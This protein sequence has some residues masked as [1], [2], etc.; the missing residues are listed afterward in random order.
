MESRYLGGRQAETAGLTP[1]PL[2]R[3]LGVLMEGGG[4]L[5]GSRQAGG[6]SGFGVQA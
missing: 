5:Q 4:T 6:G 2:K 3:R 1:E